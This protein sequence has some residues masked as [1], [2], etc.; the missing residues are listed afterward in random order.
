MSARQLK[1]VFSLMLMGHLMVAQSLLACSPSHHAGG[2]S[3]VA[4][5][6]QDLAAAT[7]T[8]NVPAH[9]NGGGKQP[10]HHVPDVPACCSLFASCGSLVYAPAVEVAT[11]LA[12]I[13]VSVP[14]DRLE[15]PL[16]HATAPE[17]PPPKQR[18][19]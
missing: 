17:P 4:H 2:Q 13:D 6:C 10:A 3:D 12:V 1:G 9:S 7:D 14:L 11:R 5:H 15:A 19:H 8:H 18:S 16:S